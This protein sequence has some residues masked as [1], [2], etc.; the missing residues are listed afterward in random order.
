[1]YDK[2]GI[3]LI[4][5]QFFCTINALRNASY[6]SETKNGANTFPKSMSNIINL[7]N[8]ESTD[9]SHQN[10]LS[11]ESN[12]LF[13]T[14]TSGK[15]YLTPRYACAVESAVKNTDL[16]GHIIVIMTSPTLDINTNNATYQL[17]TKHSENQIFFRYVNVDTI[18]KGTPI[19]QL[20]LNGHLRH[21]EAVHTAVQYR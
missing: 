20:H 3:C 18:F 15:N 9:C 10:L 8:I 21:H 6:I 1:M 17:Y 5:L 2:K 13:F 11:N 14:E 7:I 12:K 4:L 16:S 19:H